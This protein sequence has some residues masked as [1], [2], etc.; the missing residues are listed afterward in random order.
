MSP[1]SI[2]DAVTQ[3]ELERLWRRTCRRSQLAATAYFVVATTFLLG[4]A[5]F[6]YL[7]PIENAPDYEIVIWLTS[8]FLAIPL[9]VCFFY[10]I[11]REWKAYENLIRFTGHPGAIDG[12]NWEARVALATEFVRAGRH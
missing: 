2:Q 9:L 8:A 5:K 1:V 10:Y 12:A 6:G 4:F 3:I 7:I 11:W